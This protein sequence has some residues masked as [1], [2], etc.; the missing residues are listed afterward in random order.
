MAPQSLTP[1]NYHENPHPERLLAGRAICRASRRPIATLGAFAN[2]AR[3]FP[4]I[5]PD[6]VN[7]EAWRMFAYLVFAGLFT[8]LGL[9]PRRMP[10]LWEVVF[11]QKAAVAVFLTFFVA[12]HSAGA[13][14]ADS[15]TSIS[16]VDAVLAALT[17]A[18]YVLTR[19]W[20]FSAARA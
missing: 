11:F 13:Y 14:Y 4:T 10:G 20:A 3:A 9:F 19:G 18:C 17:L 8:L 1:D 16:A 12:A 2:A 5:A 6:R 7:I 15:A